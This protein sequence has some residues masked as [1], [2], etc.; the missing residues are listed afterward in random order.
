MALTPALPHLGI[1][2]SSNISGN[3]PSANPN[4]IPGFKETAYLL[5]LSSAGVSWSVARACT[6]GLVPGCQC[7]HS[8]HATQ[9]KWKWAGCSFSVKVGLDTARKLLRNPARL[10]RQTDS[11]ANYFRSH[12]LKAGRRV[13]SNTFWFSFLWIH[14]FSY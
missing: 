4:P 11:L 10:R 9:Q 13:G 6:M 2:L 3:M 5:A 14:C 8:H 7:D 12:N 1:P